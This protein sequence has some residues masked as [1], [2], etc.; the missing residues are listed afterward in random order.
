MTRKPCDIQLKERVNKPSCERQAWSDHHNRTAS[1]HNA[2]FLP[3]SSFSCQ[4]HFFIPDSWLY[5]EIQPRR[6]DTVNPTLSSFHIHTALQALD[7]TRRYSIAAT[8][9]VQKHA[10]ITV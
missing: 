7:Y 8:P 9:T 2:S 6:R 1:C 10:N 3:E 5:L 4:R